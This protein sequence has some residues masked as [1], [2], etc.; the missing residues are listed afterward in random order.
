VAELEGSPISEAAVRSAPEPCTV[1]CNILTSWS[2]TAF[3]LFLTACCPVSPGSGVR[4]V[5]LSSDVA[6]STLSNSI[7][8][9]RIAIK[10]LF[11]RLGR[12]DRSNPSFP[13]S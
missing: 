2:V 4:A 12:D 8:P 11:F 7:E 5:V 10:L 13:F 9:P 6:V 1:L 3:L